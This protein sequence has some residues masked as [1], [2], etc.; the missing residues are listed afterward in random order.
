MNESNSSL[1]IQR[2]S[3]LSDGIFAVAMTLL[4]FSIHLPE[5]SAAGRLATELT[6]MYHEGIGL[7]VSFWIAAMFWWASPEA[8][9]K[10]KAVDRCVV[11]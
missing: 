1:D 11:D 4:A 2:L 5:S 10:A 6:R 9:M 7:V 8:I 3:A